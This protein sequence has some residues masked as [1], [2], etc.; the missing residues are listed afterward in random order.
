M[1]YLHHKPIKKFSLE[2]TIHDD[3]SFIRLKIEYVNLLKSEMRLSGYVQRIDIDPDFTIGY[4]EKTEYY[5]FELTL[6]GIYTGKKKS[7]WIES[8]NAT[9]VIYTPKSKSNEF[10]QEQA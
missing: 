4:N 10:S 2:G 1:D 5:N 8:V 7:E 9:Q 6:Y 3:A